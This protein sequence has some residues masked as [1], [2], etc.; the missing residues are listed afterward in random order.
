MSFSCLGSAY[1]NFTRAELK[2]KPKNRARA[3]SKSSQTEP[4][5]ELALI[6]NLI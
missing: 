4:V 6:F 2:D 5:R 3:H 1:L